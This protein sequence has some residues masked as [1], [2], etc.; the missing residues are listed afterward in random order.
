MKVCTRC[1]MDS[2]DPQIRFD[3]FGVCNY[4]KDIEILLKARWSPNDEGTKILN[5]LLEK[6]KKD[7]RGKS[8]D[9]VIGLSGGI[10]SSYLT[11]LA[12]QKW[13]LR[14]LAV[15]V[16]AGWNSEIAESNIE[17]LV[18]KYKIDLFTYV[19]DWEEMRDLQL[20]YFKSGIVNQDT[21]QDHIFFSQLF[22]ITA[23]E[24]IKYIMTGTNLATESIS[25]SGWGSDA[26]D[27]KQL[28]YIHDKFGSIQLKSYDTI[29]LFQ[30]LYFTL[31]QTVVKPLNLIA[32]DKDEAVR[33]LVQEVQWKA[34]G[35]KHGESVFTR[36]F[37]NYWLPERYGID[38]R[39]GHLTSMIM[40]G[41]ITRDDAIKELEKPLYDPHQLKLDIEYV[42]NKLEIDKQ[43]LEKYLTMEKV[44]DK[45]YP[46]NEKIL[47][48]IMY[49]K[50][51]MK[52]R[53]KS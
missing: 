48:F 34:Y 44:T 23:K 33:F 7:G 16:N 29:S 47:A 49:M 25:I 15:H 6:I 8:Y 53:H 43:E 42:C 11:Y 36:F 46:S 10:D 14:V 32:Y 2:G 41:M 38:K 13:G 30:R 51:L 21:P 35:I 45:S 4:C 27:S 18:N 19:V 26:M 39:K 3:E 37:Q 40:S 24:K 52:F 12:T 1:V 9:C 5:D 22:K 20:S 50:N 28:H 31:K 17:K